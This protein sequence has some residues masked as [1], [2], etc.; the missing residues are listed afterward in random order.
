MSVHEDT[1]MAGS[2]DMAMVGAVAAVTDTAG[3]AAN[4]ANPPLETVNFV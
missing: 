3:S 1:G 4:Y 2:T